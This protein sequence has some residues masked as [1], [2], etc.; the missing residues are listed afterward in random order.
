MTPSNENLEDLFRVLPDI[1][2]LANTSLFF[3]G[4]QDWFL[5]AII[6]YR[7][8]S[9]YLVMAVMSFDI[10]LARKSLTDTA[11]ANKIGLED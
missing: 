7:F 3:E 4:T 2:M 5:S 10:E 11:S 1:V 8:F 6:S 9:P